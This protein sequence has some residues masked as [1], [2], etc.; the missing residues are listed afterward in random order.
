MPHGGCAECHLVLAAWRGER[1]RVG[2][3]KRTDAGAGVWRDEAGVCDGGSP[4]DGGVSEESHLPGRREAVPLHSGRQC[5]L[6]RTACGRHRAA[7][8]NPFRRC[9]KER[10][11]YGRDRHLSCGQGGCGRGNQF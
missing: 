4:A 1:D 11:V 3:G 5:S 2:E 6:L 10:R 9:E 8:P 7:P